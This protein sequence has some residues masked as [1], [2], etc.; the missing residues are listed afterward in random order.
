MELHEASEMYLETILVLERERGVVHAIDIAN[1][2]GFSRPT[3]SE[4]VNKLK[5][6][7]YLCVLESGSIEL[8]MQ[9]QSIAESIFERHV[10]LTSVLRH[11]GVSE[12]I[13]REDACRV[14]HYISDETFSCIRNYYE[15]RVPAG[16]RED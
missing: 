3:V 13:A 16:A 15:T 10:V 1:H 14:E 2:L 4:Y 9:G 5:N 12:D 11:L 8:T 7:G 6:A